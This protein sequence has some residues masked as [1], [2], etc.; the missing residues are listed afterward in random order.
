MFVAAAEAMISKNLHV[1]REFYVAPAYD[2]M[3]NG[4]ARV[5]FYNI[6]TVEKG[7]HG[8]GTPEDLEIFLSTSIAKEISASA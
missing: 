7:M 6:G 5:G 3:I 1:N 4:G 2:Q 8:L